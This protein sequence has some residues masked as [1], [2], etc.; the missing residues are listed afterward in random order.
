M[1]T[2]VDYFAATVALGSAVT[3]GIKKMMSE[4][5]YVT[6]SVD[7]QK[8]LVQDLPDKQEASDYLAKL[9]IVLTNLIRY[10]SDKYPNDHRVTRLQKRYEPR[11]VS[12]G[13]SKSG[14]TSYSVNKG[15]KIVVCIRQT[16]SKFVDMNEVLYV[17]IHELAHLATDEIGHTEKFW[18][19]FSFLLENAVDF[20]IY[21]YRDYKK[22][23]TSY[24]GIK[25]T[26]T[27]LN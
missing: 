16:D 5:E 9:N 2:F 14:Y 4:V 19:N 3:F 22:N 6:S 1:A 15:E 13:S 8:Y 26:S 11:N 25:L 20:G 24:C 17:V 18:K 12:E 10:L 23:P 27:I 21:E 7:N